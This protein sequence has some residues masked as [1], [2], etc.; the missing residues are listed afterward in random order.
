M[1]SSLEQVPLN[2]IGSLWG[3]AIESKMGSVSS[4]VANFS[5]L[6]GY[7]VQLDF[8]ETA[9]G[10]LAVE[11][12]LALDHFPDSTVVKKLDHIQVLVE[13]GCL[14]VEPV[15]KGGVETASAALASEGHEV[16]RL[17]ILKVPVLMS[18]VLA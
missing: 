8:K 16:W 17:S 1:N 15:L 13:R 9:C 5:G 3:L 18:P 11:E 10:F 4:D 6:L 14:L 2:T 7:S 12:V